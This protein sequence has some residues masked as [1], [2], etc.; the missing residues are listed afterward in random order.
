MRT[1]GVTPVTEAY[2]L[3]G[4]IS[5]NNAPGQPV[6]N[7][8]YNNFGAQ[9]G[10]P[11]ATSAIK[12]FNWPGWI[13]ANGYP[14]PRIGTAPTAWP[15]ADIL[16]EEAFIIAYNDADIAV[17][18]AGIEEEEIGSVFLAMNE[19]EVEIGDIEETDDEL[20]IAMLDTEDYEKTGDFDEL[21]DM[22][23][24]GEDGEEAGEEE[25]FDGEFLL[26][27][28][29]C[30]ISGEEEVDPS[31]AIIMFFNLSGLFVGRKKRRRGAQSS[32]KL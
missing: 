20:L 11:A 8:D 14:Y 5:A 17:F 9:Y 7:A 32:D 29:L 13:G 3:S 25:E 2:Y 30:E 27:D 10:E 16:G 19:P 23:F 28:L 24:E 22:E 1:N 4:T 6:S 26:M 21:E 31:I 12:G 18:S 15:I